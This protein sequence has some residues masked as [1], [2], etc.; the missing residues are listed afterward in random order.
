M[1]KQREK[2]I[3][4]LLLAKKEI[5]VN[6]L[7]DLLFASRASIRRDLASLENQ[8]LIKRTHGGARLE[9]NSISA[10]KL[11]FVMR[12]LEQSDEK[13]KIAAAASEYV[14]DYDVIFLD[15][16]SSAYALVPFLAAKNHITV[17][18]SGI[19]TLSRLGEYG[20][21]AISTGGEL[22]PSCRSLVGEEAHR[23]I[24][25]FNADSVFFSCRG[26]SEDGFLSDISDSENHVRK[27]MLAHS[28]NAYF[29]CASNKLGHKYFHNL[30]TARE[31]T[32]IFCDTDLPEGI[33]AEARQ[34]ESL[35]DE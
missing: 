30:C 21:R 15:A 1:N 27:K 25:S 26:L 23:T 34:P 17:I 28:K 22:L 8:Q 3:L 9:E 16:S 4:T 33:A 18:T 7:S 2:E 5:T 6:E 29:L 24:E 19:K 12:E 31:V 32:K 13:F 10:I 14:R 20:I 35:H 11:P